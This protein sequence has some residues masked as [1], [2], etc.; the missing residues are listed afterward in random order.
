MDLI[1]KKTHLDLS[2]Y[3]D[4]YIQRRIMYRLSAL[5]IDSYQEYIHYIKKNPIELPELQN[6]LTIHTTEWFRDHTPFE[7]L[8]NTI[9]PK[10]IQQKKE[11]TSNKTLRI[12]S[13]PCSSGQEPYTLSMIIEELYRTHAWKIPIEIYACD[14]EKQILDKAKQGKYSSFVMKGFPKGHIQKYFRQIGEDE[15]QIIPKLQHRITFF[16]QDLFTPLP[17]WLKPMDLVL[18]RNL[19]IYIS[20]KHQKMVLRH[21]Q[22]VLRPN[23]FLMLGKTESL[24]IFNPK[25]YENENAREHIYRYIPRRS[26]KEI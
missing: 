17:S 15:F 14:L 18:C 9:I 2:F 19:L 11:Q 10:L 22:Q 4:A 3:R 6:Q 8:Q 21:L 26:G 13:A 7:Y 23:G 12:L 5:N 24:L 25:G 16:S 1:R 20:R